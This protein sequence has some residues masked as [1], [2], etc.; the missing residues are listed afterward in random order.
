MS[1][2][3]D[4]LDHPD[5][6]V[7]FPKLADAAAQ[8][9]AEL[10]PPLSERHRRFV[11]EYIIDLNGRAAAIRAGYAR[12]KAGARAS[13][14]IRRPDVQLAIRAELK[15][16][17]ARTRLSGD[18]I[19]LEAMRIAFADP[20]RVAHWGPNGVELVDSDDL[21]PDDKAAVKWISVGGRK[22]ATAQ[23]FELHDKIAALH[24]LARMT[25][26]LTREPGRGRFALLQALPAEQEHEREAAKAQHAET[27][28]KLQRL[29]DAKS[30]YMA[31]QMFD[32]WKAADA[33]GK[34]FTVHDA[35]DDLK[36]RHPHWYP[37][38]VA[39]DDAS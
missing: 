9:D 11:L 22:G 37:K 32:A 2:T 7:P 38:V 39:K 30:C 16:R 13:A 27:A 35:L 5:R 14:L 3:P 4:T 33:A 12:G 23:R 15:D 17:E 31:Q 29:M 6:A 25:G 1:D 19:I 28:A 21:T 34:A 36:K 18:R 8:A 26:M 10:L 20:S 24:L